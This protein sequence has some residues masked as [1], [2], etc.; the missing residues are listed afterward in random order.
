MKIKLGQLKKILREEVEA[1]LPPAYFELEKKANEAYSEWKKLENLVPKESHDTDVVSHFKSVI[2]AL[3]MDSD[4]TFYIVNAAWAISDET[5]PDVHLRSTD[6]QNVENAIQIC[7]TRVERFIDYLKKTKPKEIHPDISPADVE[8]AG[9]GLIAMPSIR[10]DLPAVAVDYEKYTNYEAELEADIKRHVASSAHPLDKE[11]LDYI[12]WAIEKGYYPKVFKE[13][14]SE[15]VYRGLAL[16][17]QKIEALVETDLFD[18]EDNSNVEDRESFKVS[19]TVRASKRG[20]A[21]SWTTDLMIANDFATGGDWSKLAVILVAR[22]GE[23]PGKFWDLSS[24]TT[25]KGE[26]EVLALESM[27]KI[28]EVLR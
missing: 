13:P 7:L 20:E 18:K 14:T 17:E 27:I 16:S 12:K 23:N 1:K 25:F 22:V 26:K 24:S 3:K 8:E 19:K 11:H 21:S 5:E 15:F 10:S 2:D 9:L 4:K 28:C 6:Q